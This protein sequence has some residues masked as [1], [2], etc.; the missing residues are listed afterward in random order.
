MAK[1]IALYVGSDSYG[2]D[3][4][5][6]QRADGLWWER[7]TVKTRYG[8]AKSPWTFLPDTEVKHPTYLVPKVEY[9]GVP[10]KILLAEEDRT[11]YL[12][13]GFKILRRSEGYPT[14]RLP[15]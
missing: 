7:H 3:V 8:W 13:Y 4:Q 9:A 1:A 5:V 15:N 14:L 6:A 2:R 12:S 10:E 11:L